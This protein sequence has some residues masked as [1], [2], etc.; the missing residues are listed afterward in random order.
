MANFKYTVKSS[1]S[2]D[3][4]KDGADEFS[5]LKT[6]DYAKFDTQCD[7]TMVGFVQTMPGVSSEQY[8]L[9]KHKISCFWGEQE[10]HYDMEKT[11][12]VKTDSDNVK[13]AVITAQNK[14]ITDSGDEPKDD[15]NLELDAEVN[16]QV[17]SLA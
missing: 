1:I 6:G 10:T 9:Q 4:V 13:I 8:T 7:K 16:T 11:V 15:T 3:P 2:I 12:A 5:S 14:I 17:Q